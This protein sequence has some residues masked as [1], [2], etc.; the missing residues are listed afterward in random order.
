MMRMVCCARDGVES[1]IAQDVDDTQRLQDLRSPIQIVHF[2]FK[3]MH[4]YS[5]GRM[6][7][8]RRR[9]F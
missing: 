2:A 3:S 6:L 8:V 5:V 7:Y 9:N 4:V 1:S